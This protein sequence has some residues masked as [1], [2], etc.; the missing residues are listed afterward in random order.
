[1]NK[2]QKAIV[3]LSMSNNDNKLAKNNLRKTF[4]TSLSNQ[5]HVCLAF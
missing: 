5:N 4:S 2:K 3:C 1:M